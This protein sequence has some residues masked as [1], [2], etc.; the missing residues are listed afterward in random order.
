MPSR[1]AWAKRHCPDSG[2]DCPLRNPA[3][4]SY[5]WQHTTSTRSRYL[6]LRIHSKVLDFSRCWPG[7]CSLM[8]ADM[9]REVLRRQ[10]A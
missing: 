5:F 7:L 9:G 1:M 10:I 3:Q 2:R 8:L 6:V 4:R